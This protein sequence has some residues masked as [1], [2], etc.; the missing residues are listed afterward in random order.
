MRTMNMTLKRIFLLAAFCPLIATAQTGLDY[1]DPTIGGVGI[2]LQP[3]RPTV[4]L[5][6]QMVRWTP[7]R[8]DMLDDQVASY[9]LVMLSHRLG[10]AFGFLP[11]TGSFDQRMFHSRQE[12]DHERNTPYQYEAELEGCRLAFTPSKKSGI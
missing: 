10:Q 3:C 5:P 1:V 2:L 8:A 11:L 4:H 6:N 9:P 12:Y 7:L